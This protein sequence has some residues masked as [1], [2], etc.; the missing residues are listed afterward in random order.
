MFLHVVLGFAAC[1]TI[2]GAVVQTRVSQ[3]TS[4]E[5]RHFIAN[6]YGF[7]RT[8][9][10]DVGKAAQTVLGIETNLDDLSKELDREY[11]EWITKKESLVAENNALRN[12]IASFQGTLQEQ[13][14][15]HEEELLLQ[16]QLAAVQQEIKSFLTTRAHGKSAWDQENNDLTIENQRLEQQIQGKRWEQSTKATDAVKKF[17]SVKDTSRGLQQQI[18]NLNNEVLAMQ[19]AASKRRVEN[20]KTHGLLLEQNAALE[21]E[22]QG[23]QAKVVVNAQL[24]QEIKSYESHVASQIDERVAQQKLTLELQDKCK[25]QNDGLE[26]QIKAVQAGLLQTKKEMQACQSLDAENQKV[27]AILNECLASKKAR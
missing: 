3:P 10:D 1:V 11:N 25:F 9:S 20:G 18:Y 8:S 23:L 14:S 2:C 17:N 27:Q 26:M 6:T 7:L 21:K 4:V 16:S 22:M 13:R 5:D 24:Q 15:L 12:G 19:S